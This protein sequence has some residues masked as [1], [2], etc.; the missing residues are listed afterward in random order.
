MAHYG[1]HPRLTRSTPA[2]SDAVWHWF[3]CNGP[4]G[5]TFKW[6]NPVLGTGGELQLLREFICERAAG[7]PN[8]VAHARAIAVESLQS[9]DP[10][11][12]MKGIHVL[13]AVGSDEEM[14]LVAPLATEANPDIAKHAR[15]GLFERGIRIKGK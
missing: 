8:F 11:L 3:V 9:D 4:H 1:T 7:L 5:D 2:A 10:S 12:V 14:M 13:T 15:A 6:V